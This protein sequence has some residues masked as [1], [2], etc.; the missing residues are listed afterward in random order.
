MVIYQAEGVGDDPVWEQV[1][2]AVEVAVLSIEGDIAP[3][4]DWADAAG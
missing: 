1:A 2:E 4:L 3:R